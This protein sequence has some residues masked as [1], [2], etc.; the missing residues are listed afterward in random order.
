MQYFPADISVIFNLIKCMIYFIY[1]TAEN[2]VYVTTPAVNETGQLPI[3]MDIVYDTK[4]IDTNRTFEYRDNPVFTDIRPRNHL[5]VLVFLTCRTPLLRFVVDL[6]YNLLQQHI[7]RQ[8]PQQIEV[9]WHTLCSIAS[10]I[11][12]FIPLLP[13]NV[14]THSPLH[15]TETYYDYVTRQVSNYIKKKY[16][17]GVHAY[18]E[19]FANNNKV[20]CN[21]H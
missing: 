3:E 20:Q 10:F 5:T 9:M 7:L 21:T 1:S 17:S 2:A 15:M 6:P 4:R 18:I 14:K 11:H 13:T 16:T 12:S 8:N 19:L